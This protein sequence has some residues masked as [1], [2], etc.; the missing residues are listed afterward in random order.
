MLW[1]DQANRV[2]QSHRSILRSKPGRVV[3]PSPMRPYHVN[4]RFPR[5][6]PSGLRHLRRRSGAFTGL[7]RANYVSNV[8]GA[9]SLHRGQSAGIWWAA[10]LWRQAAHSCNRPIPSRPSCTTFGRTAQSRAGRSSSATH[11][12]FRLGAPCAG[13]RVPRQHPS[14]AC[15]TTPP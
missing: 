6:C 5:C 3:G 10:T 13:G 14:I 12:P 9:N 1:I 8:S 15:E 4:R 2:E 7:D 11:P